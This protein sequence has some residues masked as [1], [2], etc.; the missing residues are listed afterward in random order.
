MHFKAIIFDL[1]GTLL[2]TIGDLMDSMNL[3]LGERGYPPH[4][5]TEYKLFVGNG[6][7][8][9]TE[10]ALGGTDADE[11]TIVS[12]LNAFMSHY[13]RLQ[14]EK[15]RP[16]DGIPETL[17]TLKKRGLRLAVLSNKADINTRS[18][19]DWFFPTH[20]FEMAVGQ[21]E[22]VPAKPD[23]TAALAMAAEMGLKPEEILYIGDSS[24]DMKTANS[25][26]MYALGVLWGFRSREELIENG[27]KQLIER[28]EQIL[29][30]V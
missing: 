27:A 8:K 22:G 18:V 19:I 6:M 7:R 12:V 1:D 3:A 14:R 9:L 15:T 10:R 5:E 20:P 13:A 17:E 16:Y 26:G 11:G 21:R 23:P 25:A 29:D 30:I 24:V 2:N 4:N 28:P